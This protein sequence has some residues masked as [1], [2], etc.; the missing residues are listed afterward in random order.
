MT[1]ANAELIDWCQRQ[2]EDAA[3]Q[4]ELFGTGGVKALLLMADGTTQDITAGV[5]D[6]QTDN[7]AAYQRIIAALRA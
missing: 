3:R 1:P 5:V 2:R 4:I 6:H 7:I